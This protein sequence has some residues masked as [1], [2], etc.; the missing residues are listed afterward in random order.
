LGVASYEL[1]ELDWKDQNS[2]LTWFTQ[3]FA[4]H[5]FWATRLNL[6]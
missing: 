2:V 1:S 4:E 3:N 6:G 5:Q